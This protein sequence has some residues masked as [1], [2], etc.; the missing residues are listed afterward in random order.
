MTS[1]HEMTHAE[2]L[3]AIE[4]LWPGHGGKAAAARELGIGYRR[5][6]EFLTE[7]G[8]PSHRKIPP[9]IADEIRDL[10]E[11][12]PNGVRMADPRQVIG[13]L[14]EQM[15]RNGWRPDEAAAGILGAAFSN[16]CRHLGDETARNLLDDPQ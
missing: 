14:H 15:I 8:K 12:F 2:F 11:R 16:A 6:Q 7:P 13:A 5:V 1:P 4:T 10:L 3:A 9:G